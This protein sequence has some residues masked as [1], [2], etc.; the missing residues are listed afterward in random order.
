M[1]KETGF[2]ISV[3]HTINNV[4][5]DPDVLHEGYKGAAVIKAMKRAEHDPLVRWILSQSD[6]DINVETKTITTVS[7]AV[8]YNPEDSD[9][10]GHQLDVK[11]GEKLAD[12]SVEFVSVPFDK[13]NG[14][15]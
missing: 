3:P 10:P 15:E 6:V 11:T 1:L 13:E 2:L 12:L 5:L 14:E 7:F 4:G 9:I 8:R